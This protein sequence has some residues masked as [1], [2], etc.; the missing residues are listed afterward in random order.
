M[1]FFSKSSDR[2]PSIYIDGKAKPS[3]TIPLLEEMA[4]LE[5]WSE[6]MVP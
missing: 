2:A 6:Q 5:V 3:Y 4:E 1:F